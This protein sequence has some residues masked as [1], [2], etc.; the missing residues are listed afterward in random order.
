M[1]GSSLRYRHRAIIGPYVEWPD[2]RARSAPLKTRLWDR[3]RLPREGRSMGHPEE[4]R[5]SDGARCS[6]T[7]MIEPA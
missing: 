1:V 3:R 5:P 4:P 6:G 2:L 7:A